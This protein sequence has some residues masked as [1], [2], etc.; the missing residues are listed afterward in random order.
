MKLS[1]L[2]YI[3]S[4]MPLEEIKNP[5]Y[6]QF[7]VNEA[8]ARGIDIPDIV[9][10]STTIN[11]D[12]P[13]VILWS[14]LDMRMEIDPVTRKVVDN[15]VDDDFSI[16]PFEY[17]PELYTTKEF[18]A[19]IEWN[20]YSEGCAKHIV[21]Y[22][23]KHMEQVDEMEIWNVWLTNLE[24]PAIHKTEIKLDDVTVETIKMIDDIEV[25]RDPITYYCYTIRK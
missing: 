22:I 10:N 18:L 4:D 5:H 23:K 15:G 20:V 12:K 9:L 21:E 2:F 19:E 3:A 16:R 6:K 25:S 14:D 24:I 11:R 1:V 17:Y 13:N 7:S 8:L